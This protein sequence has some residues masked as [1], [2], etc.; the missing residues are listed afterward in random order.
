[1]AGKQIKS[2]AKDTA[3]YGLSN[4]IGK[5]INWLLV[6]LYTRTLA[7]PSDYGVVTNLYSWTA[8]LLVIL[9]YGME[10]GFFRFI[11][12]GKDAPNR[13]YSTSMIS[14]GSTSLLFAVL[15]VALAPQCATLL[16]LPA[17]PEYI[18]MLGIS[19]ALDAFASIPFAYLRYCK[20]PIRFA[21]IKLIYVVLNVLINLFFFVACPYLLK[22]APASV[23][24]FY[25]P[26]YGVGYVFVA[27]I[28]S[29]IIQT[30]FLV[31]Y[32]VVVRFEFD[33]ALLRRILRYSL[34]LLLLGIAGTMNQTLDKILYPYL[35]AGIGGDIELGIYG[36]TSK[37]ALIMLMFTQAFRFAYEPFVFAQ[38]RSPK[39]HDSYIQAM[40]FFV[41]VSWF[42][43]L[44]MIFYI[45]IFKLIIPEQ[46]W[47]GFDAV[48]IILV[49]FIFQGIYFNLSIWY[50]L[51]DRT[52]FGAWFSV[53][54][55]AVIVAGNMLLVPRFGYY[56]CAWAAFAC[57]FLVMLLSYFF[58]QK[59]M[60]IA[61][62][63]KKI[64]F[65]TLIALILFVLSF[66]IKTSYE[67]LNYFIKTI[68]VIIYLLIFI[69]ND[70]PVKKIPV[71]NKLFKEIKN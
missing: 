8:L 58:G 21:A 20:M 35:R 71:L 61:Y 49:S 65:Y 13:I 10:T 5:S 43:F 38:K 30:L 31:R 4:I 12:N 60:P 68:L 69:K 23:Q 55:T 36:A 41:V 19:V 25:D 51:S 14:V 53:A 44:G 66:L 34:P 47:S 27:N 54:G 67:W 70:L 64:G 33:K 18:R 6:P 62:N 3:I 57:Y 63:L 45:D 59:Y 17:H 22:H 29:T 37:V 48:P 28:I 7:S 52:M 39:H 50:K 11:N 40:N 9:T 46:Y 16:K 42:I 24:W 26:S 2:L 15:I 32:I 56:G 1:M